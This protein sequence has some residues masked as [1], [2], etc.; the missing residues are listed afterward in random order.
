MNKISSVMC[1]YR[2]F[3]CVERSVMMWLLQDYEGPEELII[4][5][6]DEEFPL[7]LG[8]SF[9]PFQTPTKN[10][11][12]INN[13]IDLETHLPYTNTGAIRRD[14]IKFATGEY[15]ICWDDDDV[16]LPWNNRQCMD[17]IIRTEKLA[18]KPIYSL[19][20]TPN[21]LEQAQNTLEASII[22]HLPTLRDIGFKLETASEHLGWYT[23]LAYSGKMES[24][25]LCSVPGYSFNW[26]DPPDIAGH[27][28][29]GNGATPTNFEDHKR[30]SRDIGNRPL[31]YQF[32]FTYLDPYFQY[33][34]ENLGGSPTP[35]TYPCVWEPEVIEKYV[36]KYI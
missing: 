6:T 16:F 7:V 28:Q 13:G 35:V 12:I 10:I 1:T 9:Q 22:V 25:E 4:Y 23:E 11:R 36:R 24:S 15:Y 5:N 18:W 27:K 2:R 14:S 3:T 17:G 19:F 26:S 21:R 8:S 34:R 20:T 29:S 32:N 33:F 30:A 31:N